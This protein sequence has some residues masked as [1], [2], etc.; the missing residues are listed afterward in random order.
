MSKK[1]CIDPEGGIRPDG[2]CTPGL[3]RDGVKRWIKVK[4]NDRDVDGLVQ[5]IRKRFDIEPTEEGY[6]DDQFASYDDDSD[7]MTAAFDSGLNQY[8]LGF[9]DSKVDGTLV[10]LESVE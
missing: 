2:E 1:V 6:D 8:V 3:V 10:L 4:G 5:S 7:T 9:V